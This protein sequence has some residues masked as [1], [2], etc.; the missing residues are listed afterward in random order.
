ML[1]I[2]GWVERCRVQKTVVDTKFKTCTNLSCHRFFRTK[3]TSM[4]MNYKWNSIKLGSSAHRIVTKTLHKTL[5][6]VRGVVGV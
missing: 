1:G 3:T 5:P 6:K 2:E 4:F